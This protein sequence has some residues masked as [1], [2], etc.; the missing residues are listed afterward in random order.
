MVSTGGPVSR[1]ASRRSPASP[2][3]PRIVSE[4]VSESG[5]YCMAP[6]RWIA[7]VVESAM[8]RQASNSFGDPGNAG[9]SDLPLLRIGAAEDFL[10]H[11]AAIDIGLYP[12]DIV[13][14]RQLQ[15]FSRDIVIRLL[16]THSQLQSTV[17]VERRQL[18]VLTGFHAEDA[19]P[20]PRFHERA[21]G[22]VKRQAGD[23]F[24]IG[25]CFELALVVVQRYLR[26]H[27][28]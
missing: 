15:G 27:M 28:P 21:E 20:R 14:R 9:M 13:E 12:L 23:Q 19:D 6:M 11:V 18:P 16:Q 1:S 22:Q 26:G 7:R 8:T 5:L 25:I 24:E 3:A 2:V 4:R 17:V 10:Q